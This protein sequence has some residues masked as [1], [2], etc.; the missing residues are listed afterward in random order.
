MLSTL[1][2]R[3]QHGLRP[4]ALISI[5][6]IDSVLS[7]IQESGNGFGVPFLTRRILS[8]LSIWFSHS[9]FS[10]Y[11]FRASRNS[12]LM[13]PGFLPLSGHGAMILL[14]GHIAGRRCRPE[15]RSQ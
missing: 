3:D 7:G 4:D 1:R 6:R 8:S 9:G 14:S 10:A 13:G 5:S 11:L 15:N 12:Q 2:K